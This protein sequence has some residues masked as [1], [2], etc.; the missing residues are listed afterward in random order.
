MNFFDAQDRA[1]RATKWLVVVYI[2]ATALIVAGVTLIVG[3]GLFSV[4]MDGRPLDLAVLGAIAIVATL[5]IF[6]ASLYKTSRLS[7][8]GA[9]LVTCTAWVEVVAA[10]ELLACWAS[11]VTVV[12]L[13]GSGAAWQSSNTLRL[14]K[15]KPP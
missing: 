2:I 7:A 15:L 3:V 11:E 10:S 8:G 9:T 13:S 12:P 6:G 5:F 4:G 14:I 1:R